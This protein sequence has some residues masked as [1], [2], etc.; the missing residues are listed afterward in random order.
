M[1]KIKQLQAD[2]SSIQTQIDKLVQEGSQQKAKL[3]T[4]DYSDS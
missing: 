3:V 4:S 1:E 2:L